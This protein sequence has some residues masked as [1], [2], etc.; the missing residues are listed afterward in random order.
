MFDLEKFKTGDY[1]VHLPTYELYNKVIEWLDEEGFVW[2]LGTK[3]YE[4]DAWDNFKGTTCISCKYDGSLFVGYFNLYD[5][6]YEKLDINTEKTTLRVGD[7]VRIKSDRIDTDIM[8]Q[9][10][11][12]YIS[13]ID[14]FSTPIYV[15]VK[16][17][18]LVGVGI[19]MLGFDDYDMFYEHELEK[20]HSHEEVMSNFKQNQDVVINKPINLEGSNDLLADNAS[21]YTKLMLE[22]K[23]IYLDKN[24][25]YGDA[26]AETIQKYGYI[27][28]LTRMNDK[29]N[30]IEEFTLKG[31][32]DEEE[33]LRDSLMDLANYC[34]M[35][36]MEIEKEN[37]Q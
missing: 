19:T 33:S 24:E 12:G 3:L 32:K 2:N 14:H 7:K 29:F 15:V 25:K 10:D 8:Q 36:V 22:N 13:N 1:Y 26:F 23:S 16:D 28:A 20:L 4:Y 37:K 31:F 6:V 11:I 18:G 5:Q 17:V 34:Y 30:R 27:S 9:G 35:Y 21:H